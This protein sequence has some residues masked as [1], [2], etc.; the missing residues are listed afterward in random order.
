M[1]SS[2]FAIISHYFMRYDRGYMLFTPP[3]GNIFRMYPFHRKGAEPTNRRLHRTKAFSLRRR[4]LTERMWR[5]ILEQNH[6]AVGDQ[7]I[8]NYEDR[9]ADRF[10]PEEAL[11]MRIT[12]PSNDRYGRLMALYY[13]SNFFTNPI[14]CKPFIS[15][16]WEETSSLTTFCASLR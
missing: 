7:I 11:R 13:Y 6:I 16:S 8:I 10:T 12:R 15:H 2:K 4:C 1:H 3:I 9:F 14:Y 5:V